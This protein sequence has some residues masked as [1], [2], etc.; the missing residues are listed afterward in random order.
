MG[1]PS[2]VQRRRPASLHDRKRLV[3]SPA[4][5]VQIPDGCSAPTGMGPAHSSEREAGEA[6][7]DVSM[8]A[9]GDPHVL[10]R[11]AALWRRRRPSSSSRDVRRPPASMPSADTK[12]MRASISSSSAMATPRDDDDE[13]STLPEKKSPAPPRMAIW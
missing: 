4:P 2:T 7:A 3:S 5:P 10:L 1:R 8:V 11:A 12:S 13:K 9:G 6:E